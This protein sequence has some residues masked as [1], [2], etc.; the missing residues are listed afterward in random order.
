M[1]RS[2]FLNKYREAPE[3]GPKNPSLPFYDLGPSRTGSFCSHTVSGK[4]LQM[5]SEC[6]QAF[7]G[8][9][10][11]RAY[12]NKFAESDATWKN[13]QTKDES[14]GPESNG[15]YL[16]PEIN[17][18]YCADAFRLG[19]LPGLPSHASRQTRY[20]SDFPG[21]TTCDRPAIE[22]LAS[23]ILRA[24]RGPK[25]NTGSCSARI[26]TDRVV[27]RTPKAKNGE[28]QALRS[29]P[30]KGILATDV[31]R[32]IPLRRL[33]KRRDVHDSDDDCPRAP[34]LCVH[35][36]DIQLWHYP[37]LDDGDDP[38]HHHHALRTGHPGSHPQAA[39][40]A[41]ASTRSACSR[42]RCLD[43]SRLFVSFIHFA[44]FVSALRLAGEAFWDALRSSL[45][46]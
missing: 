37:H 41:C 30:E 43:R 20:R 31:N 5:H 22:W 21:I 23:R 19:T 12:L 29:S 32:A 11:P 25:T 33:E 10:G 17:L 38:H 8:I 9:L 24:F 2:L 18:A 27:R 42:S 15:R 45:L 6:Y 4:F 16:L 46:P 1:H 3:T 13:M 26:S 36:R 7:G 34:L 28:L 44:A 14:P 39:R 40:C 35:L